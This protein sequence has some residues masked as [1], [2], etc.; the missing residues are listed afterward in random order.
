LGGETGGVPSGA[1]GPCA[2]PVGTQSTG[3][4]DAHVHI[5]PPEFVRDRSS[6]LGRDEW[7]NLLYSDPRARIVDAEGLLAEM[8]ACGI[9]Q[10]VVF[11]FP[12][13][14]PGLCRLAN[15]Y[16]MEAVRAHPHRLAG[17]ACV[18][19]EE[20]GAVDEAARCLDAGLVGCGELVLRADALDGGWHELADFLAGRDAALLLHANEP[21]GH[22]YPGKGRFPLEVC[23]AYV[24]AHPDLTLVLGHMG[25]G[26]LFYELMPEV[27]RAFTRV[28]YDTAAVPYLYDARLY[29]AAVS[30]AGA[31]K[32]IFGSDFPLLSPA[33]YFDQMEELGPEERAEVLGNNARRV[34]G[35]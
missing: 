6:L 5:L 20:P 35:L 33:R 15:D 18:S 3:I 31:E 25:G 21:V 32:I 14:D 26:I 29:P 12:F 19:P 11:G 28:Y 8:D 9:A 7:F 27:R 2:V 4:V 30:C 1:R 23:A 22:V 34:F 17:L 13:A 10:S 16:V 24:T